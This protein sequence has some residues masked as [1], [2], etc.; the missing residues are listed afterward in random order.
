MGNSP[1]VSWLE[2][3]LDCKASLLGLQHKN[4]RFQISHLSSA[5]KE[6]GIQQGQSQLWRTWTEVAI[7]QRRIKINMAKLIKTEWD[8][9]LF[10]Q[11]FFLVNCRR[12]LCYYW[13]LQLW[14]FSFKNLS[15]NF[16]SDEM[17]WWWER[18]WRIQYGVGN[19]HSG[20]AYRSL[21]LF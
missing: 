11:R 19:R 9:I 16:G 20:R 2:G 5:K 18:K 12:Y 15:Y 17:V 1:F 13:Q 21:M 7:R 4:H 8:F 6:R 10:F 14:K 3:Q